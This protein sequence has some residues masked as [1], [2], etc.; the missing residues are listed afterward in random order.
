MGR[1]IAMIVIGIVKAIAG[2]KE[3]ASQ[4]KDGGESEQNYFNIHNLL[5]SRY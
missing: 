4:N 3:Q 5:I 2:A 1:A